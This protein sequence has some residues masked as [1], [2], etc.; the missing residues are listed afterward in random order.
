MELPTITKIG[1]NWYHGYAN[2]AQ[3]EVTVDKLPEHKDFIYQ[4]TT[5]WE[6]DPVMLISQNL[7]P[8]VKFV[9]IANRNGQ[10]QFDGALGGDY[11]LT[12]GQVLKSRTGWS[13]RSGVI[14]RDYAEWIPDDIMEP[15]VIVPLDGGKY[16]SR[17]AGFAIVA[18]YIREHPMWPK[19]LYLICSKSERGEI[20][21]TPSIHPTKIEKEAYFGL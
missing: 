13:S 5:D 10:S 11:K 7:A 19:G 6:K 15:T 2:S 18:K 17:W 12:N 4:P 16:P 8:W 14:N 20:N 9:Y 3:L 21:Y 1:V